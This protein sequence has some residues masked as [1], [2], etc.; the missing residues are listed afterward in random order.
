[1]SHQIIL[2]Y[3]AA[4]VG[5]SACNRVYVHPFNLFSFNK[6]QCEKVKEQNEPVSMGEMYTPI[7]IESTIDPE[8]ETFKL[9]LQGKQHESMENQGLSYLT[10][11]MNH[12][13]FRFFKELRETH[14]DNTVLMSYTNLY[15]TLVSF[16][17]GSAGNTSLDLQNILGFIDPSGDKNCL[18]RLDGLKVISKLKTLDNL[19]LSKDANIDALK[20]ACIF[21]STG[22]PLYE[23]FVLNLIPS[24]DEFHVKAVDFKNPLKAAVLINDFLDSQSSKKSKYV[25]TDIDA[26]TNLLYTSYI[27]FKGKV[28]NSFAIP[29]L[30]DYWIESDRKISVPMMSI[31]GMFQYKIDNTANQLILKIPLSE[32]DF[33]LL[34]QPINGNTIEHIE[35]SFSWESFSTWLNNLSN[36]YIRL[37]MP[38]LEIE[39]S[40]DIQE[41]LS[42]MH[43]S[44]LLGKDADFR[45]ISNADITVGQIINKVHFELEESGKANDTEDLS[46][47][48]D[49][50]KPLEFNV[51]SPF[52]LAVFE[53][54][55]K[56]LLFVSKVINPV[57][58][59]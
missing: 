14:K 35:S 25:L 28:K 13:G 26:S 47:N 49:N 52:L 31:S 22:V 33:M 7:S 18:S 45:K 1:M 54:T 21:V 48:K 59:F 44:Y 20:T 30:Q 5:F 57:K 16:Y 10:L 46:V 27:H 58:V 34:I 53:G 6:T 37:C 42:T 23:K 2:L 39:S 29:E 51:N 56:A 40:Y 15:L 50:V 12:L 24:A 4:C 8:E 3:L 19:L 36:R 17:L 32:N 9:L 41:L 11:L 43:L 38:K 55:T